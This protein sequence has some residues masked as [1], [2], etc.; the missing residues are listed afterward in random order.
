MPKRD[1]I[2][3]NKRTVTVEFTDEE[4]KQRLISE[5][6]AEEDMTD[7]HGKPAQGVT[8]KCI[9]HNRGFKVIITQDRSAQK[10]LTGSKE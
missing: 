10:L 1:T 2:D 8:A 6:I 3:I 9:R 4:I 5:A 7:Q